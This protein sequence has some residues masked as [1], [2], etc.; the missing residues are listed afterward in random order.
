MLWTRKR[1]KIFTMPINNEDLI[2]GTVLLEGGGAR[3]VFSSG[4]LDYLMEQDIYMTDVIGVSAGSC[5]AVDYVSRQIGRTRDCMIH[6]EKELEYI[7]FKSLITQRS[8]FNMDML[9]DKYPNDLF[10]F[11]YDT[12][13]ASSMNCEIVVTNCATGKPEYI[14]AEKGNR[15]KLMAYLRA[16][17]SMP[18]VSPVV[19]IDGVPY[20]DGGVTDSVP[21]RRAAALG[22]HKII[23]VLTR[24]AEYEKEP[25]KKWNTAVYRHL[26][27]KYPKLIEAVRSRYIRYNR[28]TELIDRL[29]RTG[30]IFVIRPECE[31]IG[32]TEKDYDKLMA[33]YQHGY[34]LMKERMG[35]LEEYL[36]EPLGNED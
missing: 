30:K 16:S 11:D 2:R 35:E 25:L 23:A 5:N 8:L 31:L 33:F 36:A 9:F 20:L 19:M 17:S 26:Y 13:F 6:K 12:F 10:P 32:R 3:G 27:H 22:N 18:L 1:E 21:I 4:V 7:G 14:V 34:D 28:T 29:E 15:E 24:D